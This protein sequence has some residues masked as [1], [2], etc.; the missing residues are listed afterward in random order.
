MPV[1]T[2]PVNWYSFPVTTMRPSAATA[3]PLAS[4]SSPLGMGMVSHPSPL[5]VVSA[6]PLALKRATRKSLMEVDPA[7]RAVPAATTLPSDCTASAK[8]VAAAVPVEK[9]RMP[10]PSQVVSGL[11][12]A[13]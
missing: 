1:L 4:L 9:L 6:E 2:P 3:T 7:R 8:N 11:P 12:A 5:N 10:S 13:V